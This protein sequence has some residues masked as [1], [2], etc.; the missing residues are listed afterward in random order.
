MDIFIDNPTILINITRSW[1]C[2]NNVQ[3]SNEI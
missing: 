1:R 2:G 3:N